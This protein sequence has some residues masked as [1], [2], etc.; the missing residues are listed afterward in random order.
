MHWVDETLKDIE[1]LEQNW[2]GYGAQQIPQQVLDKA[3]EL[4]KRLPDGF[5]VFPTARQSVQF[6]FSERMYIETE[7]FEDKMTVMFV[8]TTSTGRLKYKERKNNTVYYNEEGYLQNVI[9]IIKGYLGIVSPSG[10]KR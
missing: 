5:V 8:P 6:E 2:N 3:K 10:Q 9:G 1:Y 4:A 7:V